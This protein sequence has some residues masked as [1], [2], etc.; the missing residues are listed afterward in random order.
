MAQAKSDRL[1]LADRAANA[2]NNASM[3]TQGND[4]GSKK[5]QHKLTDLQILGMIDSNDDPQG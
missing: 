3:M 5:R 4:G 2:H 1:T